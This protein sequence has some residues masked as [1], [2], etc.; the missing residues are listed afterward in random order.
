MILG[1]SLDIV[2]EK[3]D[4]RIKTW[5]NSKEF[6]NFQLNLIYFIF[7]GVLI[8]A[9]S[10]FMDFSNWKNLVLFIL[11]F[12]IS[13]LLGF[14]YCYGLSQYINIKWIEYV[15]FE[16]SYGVILIL[17]YLGLDFFVFLAIIPII[18]ILKK[19]NIIRKNMLTKTIEDHDKRKSNN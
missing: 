12:S 6:K 3:K 16:L 5:N 4:N 1:E 18:P 2:I 11:L 8:Y 9:A 10:L 7:S 15:L 14:R 19:E 17:L 13:L